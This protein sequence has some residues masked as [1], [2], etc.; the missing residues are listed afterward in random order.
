MSA[1]AEKWQRSLT[2][3]AVNAGVAVLGPAQASALLARLATLEAMEQRCR[4]AIESDIWISG[5]DAARHILTG[6]DG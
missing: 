3:A 1:E 2:H 5:T 6:E 4:E